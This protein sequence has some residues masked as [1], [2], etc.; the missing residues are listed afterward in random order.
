ME[1]N[2]VF[3]L[4]AQSVNATGN[5]NAFDVFPYESL[6]FF[7]NLTALSGGTTP[8]VQFTYQEVD[9]YGVWY[10]VTNLGSAL[11]AIGTAR[12]S[13]GEGAKV[14]EAIGK[15]GRIKWTV[16]GGPTTATANI[17]VIGNDQD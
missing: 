7:V 14:N 10:D 15:S 16:T 5:S 9:D 2:T 11:T 13:V 3:D 8:S 1:Q 17:T 12:T 6:S 4:G